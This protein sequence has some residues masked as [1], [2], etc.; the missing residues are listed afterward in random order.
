M[1]TAITSIMKAL[2]KRRNKCVLFAQ[3]ANTDLARS[4]WKG[5]LTA[6]KRASVMTA[7]I[8]QFD[9][10]YVIY[11]DASDMALFFD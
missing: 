4:F 11:E 8:S 10:R 2:R 6:T 9:S 5:K 3:V 7:L 1:S